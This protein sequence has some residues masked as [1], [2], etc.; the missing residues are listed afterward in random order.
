MIILLKK[1]YKT[2]GLIRKSFHYTRVVQ[3]KKWCCFST[4]LRVPFWFQFFNSVKITAL[5][6]F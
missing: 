5:I 2:L 4:A 1:V 3:A 6:E